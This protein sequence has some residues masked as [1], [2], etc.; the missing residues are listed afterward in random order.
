M[1]SH[2][3]REREEGKEVAHFFYRRAV[4]SE[5]MYNIYKILQIIKIS[6]SLKKKSLHI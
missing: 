6:S 5:T 4:F 3:E 1:D 2:E